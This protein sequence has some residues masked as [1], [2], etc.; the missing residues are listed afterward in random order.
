MRAQ[1]QGKNREQQ[2]GGDQQ[3]GAHVATTEI[4]CL[5]PRTRREP[6]GNHYGQRPNISRARYRTRGT[7]ERRADATVKLTAPEKPLKGVIVTCAIPELP[8]AD[9]EALR[10]NDE[11]KIR[12][13]RCC[14]QKKVRFRENVGE[15]EVHSVTRLFAS[16]EPS[17]VAKS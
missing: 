8:W 6:C 15:T 16:T 4:R 14:Q 7:C 12:H 17:P 10:R 5:G 1:S 13:G 9:G 3:Q 2:D 11:L